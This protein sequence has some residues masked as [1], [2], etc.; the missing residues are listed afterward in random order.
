MERNI[1]LVWEVMRQARE[2]R[3]KHGLPQQ[4]LAALAKVRRSTLN[5]FETRKVM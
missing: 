1:R 5:R 2:R 3:K 4:H